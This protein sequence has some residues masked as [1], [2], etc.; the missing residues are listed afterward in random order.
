MDQLR[1]AAQQALEAL[2]QPEQDSVAWMVY[3]EDGKSAY[4]EEIHDYFQRRHR[5][6]AVERHRG[7]A[8]GEE[9]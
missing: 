9:L 1:Q 2:K 5:D 3:T 8:E 4:V 6:K 7:R